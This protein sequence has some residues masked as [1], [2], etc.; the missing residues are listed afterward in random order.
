MTYA[1]VKVISMDKE[2]DK[3][4]KKRETFLLSLLNYKRLRWNRGGLIFPPPAV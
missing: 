2:E 1:K 4:K 3:Q